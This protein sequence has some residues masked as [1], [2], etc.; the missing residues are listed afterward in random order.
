ML[1]QC[2][3]CAHKGQSCCRNVHIYL[4][5]GDIER[6]SGLC[7][8]ETFCEMAPLTPDYE[9][10]GGDPDWNP[11]ILNAD[12]TRRVM[13]QQPDGGCHFLTPTG[14]RLPSDVRPLLCRIYPYEFR[15]WQLTG[16]SP[17]CPVAS[18]SDWLRILE[19]SEMKQANARAWVAQ[20]AEEIFAEKHDTPSKG[21]A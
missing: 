7:P 18:E 16:I 3:E 12:G 4:T 5:R 2:V 8:S 19:D 14:C 17:S 6:I 1:L 20:L 21:A 15:S 11:A 13:R 10:A 9:D